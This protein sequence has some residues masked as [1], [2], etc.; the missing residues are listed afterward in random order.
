MF[1]LDIQ[2]STD[3][4]VYPT[5][6]FTGHSWSAKVKA[7]SQTSGNFPISLLFYVFNEGSEQLSYSVNQNGSLDYISGTVDKV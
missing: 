2:I 4:L 7:N 5:E 6:T 3:F 1:L